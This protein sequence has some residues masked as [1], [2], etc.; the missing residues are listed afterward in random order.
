MTLTFRE[1]SNEIILIEQ[2]LRFLDL[3]EEQAAQRLARA[4]LIL[5]YYPFPDFKKFFEP[6]IADSKT[7]IDLLIRDKAIFR[8]K[9]ADAKQRANIIDSVDVPLPF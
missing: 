6:I 8:Q 9:L 1:R 4:S 2:G 5:T 7:E 3:L